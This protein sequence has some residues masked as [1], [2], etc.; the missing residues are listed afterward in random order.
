MQVVFHEWDSG[1]KLVS[2]VRHVIPECPAP[3]HDYVITRG[4]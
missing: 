3:P 1:F 2:S 4:S